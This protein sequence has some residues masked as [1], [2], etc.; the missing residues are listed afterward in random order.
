MDYTSKAQNVLDIA[1][2]WAKR[3]KQNYIGTEHILLGLVEE[4]TG[5]AARVLAE[6]GVKQEQLL[7]MIEELISTNNHLKEMVIHQEQRKC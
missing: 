1:V 5:V 7:E 3:L 4:E 6:N 2:K